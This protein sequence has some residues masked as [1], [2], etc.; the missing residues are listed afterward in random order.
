[1]N[2]QTPVTFEKANSKVYPV[3]VA[4]A[5]AKDSEGKYNPVTLGWVTETSVS[6]RMYSIAIN[7]SNYSLEVIQS[8]KEFVLAFPSVNMAE[9]T[10]FFGTCSGRDKDKFSKVKLATEPARNVDSL[11][12]TDAVSNFEC[13]LISEHPSGDHVILVGEVVGAYMNAD[14]AVER[15]YIIGPG[16]KMGSYRNMT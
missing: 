14:P 15:L 5:I 9:E 12:L 4:I 6:P 13:K 10:L 11:L 2:M 1:M 8:T 7:R 3:P 16:F